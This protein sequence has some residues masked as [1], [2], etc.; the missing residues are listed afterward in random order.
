MAK[1]IELMNFSA[2]DVELKEEM[3]RSELLSY[4]EKMISSDSNILAV[5]SFRQDSVLNQNHLFSAVYHSWNA[6]KTENMISK[7]LSVEFLLYLSGQRQITKAFEMF[8]LSDR[9]KNFSI[10]IFHIETLIELKDY[11]TNSPL[12]SICSKTSYL[13][14]SDT[15]S[16][17][18]E[19]ANLFSYS[20]LNDDPYLLSEEGYSNLENF[21]LSS[22]SNVVFEA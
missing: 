13:K 9:V 14:L 6:F 12:G 15:L 2:F 18:K 5:Q 7:S 19:L 3:N 16:K 4:F 21:I 1:N 17:R 22:I 8:G 20:Y 10:I 11:I